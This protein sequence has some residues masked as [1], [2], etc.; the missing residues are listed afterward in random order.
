MKKSRKI[1]LFLILITV[2]ITFG[3]YFTNTSDVD[4]KNLSHVLIIDRKSGVSEQ[5]VPWSKDLY[6]K[7]NYFKG[8][9]P[10]N[11][12]YQAHTYTWINI[13]SSL[14]D[15][16]NATG[17][18][19][20]FKS[21]NVTSYFRDSISWVIEEQIQKSDSNEILKH[22]Q[23][24]F[25]IA[26]EYAKKIETDMRAK[27]MGKS[28]FCEGKDIIILQNCVET[29]KNMLRDEIS[30]PIF[31]DWHDVENNHY[32]PETN[33]GLNY[34]VQKLWNDRFDKLRNDR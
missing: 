23:G 26:E 10:K 19:F 31:S 17:V 34:S 20:S 18:E 14:N 24:H 8:T 25:D 15:K 33:H 9:V 11:N 4:E 22:E 12:E 27:L 32:D 13:T 21:I 7:W 2:G 29:K 30:N 6:L 5:M 28:F 16:K 1:I 3:Y